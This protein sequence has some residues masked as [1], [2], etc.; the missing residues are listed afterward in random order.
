MRGKK[1][2]SVYR[3]PVCEG[4]G[5]VPAGFYYQNTS[6]SVVNTCPEL[7]R[8]CGGRGV[9]FDIDVFDKNKQSN[10]NLATTHSAIAVNTCS[11]CE[12][13]DGMIYTSNP[14][15]WKCTF[16]NEWHTADYYCPNYSLQ[17]LKY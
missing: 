10:G 5:E 3:C 8:S 7:C 4:R 14:P 6:P 1:T 11:N 16:T 15:K 17:T 9:I 13:N 2:V 12:H